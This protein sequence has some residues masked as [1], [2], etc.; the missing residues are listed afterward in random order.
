VTPAVASTPPGRQDIAEAVIVTLRSPVRVAAYDGRP[1]DLERALRRAAHAALPAAIVR[2]RRPV[3]RRWI[4]NAV[5]LRAPLQEIR[6]LAHD[7]AVVRIEPDRRVRVPAARPLA[8]DPAP[9]APFASGDWGLA[10]IF[11]P[12]VWRAY[13]IDG[14][15][16]RVGSIDSGV[17]RS[18]PDL[19]GRVAAWRDFVNGRPLPY[20]DNGHGPHT[21]A[22]M[23]GGSARGRP[24]GVAPGA[25]GGVAQALR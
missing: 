3:R 21:I 23:V 17:D 8:D 20:D 12:A 2:S 16:V 13:G 22:T 7:P 18:H 5:A 25:R 1:R 19:A 10:A 11:A 15:G 6:R 24:G 9:P 14:S 4:P